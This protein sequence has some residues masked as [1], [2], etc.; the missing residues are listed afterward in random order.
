MISEKQF[1]FWDKLIK[2][3]FDVQYELIIHV[4]EPD[5]NND[6]YC[7]IGYVKGIIPIKTVIRVNVEIYNNY[8][9][10]IHV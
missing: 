5:K 8:K 9:Q 4:I 7:I 10:L 3:E 6:D 1:K 2:E